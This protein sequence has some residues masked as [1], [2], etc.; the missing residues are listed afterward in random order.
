M[1]PA[2]ADHEISPAESEPQIHVVNSTLS[3]SQ[4]LFATNVGRRK[5]SARRYQIGHCQRQE[6]RILKFKKLFE[7]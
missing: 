4:Y 6:S 1:T 7:K 3:A 2:E 5:T